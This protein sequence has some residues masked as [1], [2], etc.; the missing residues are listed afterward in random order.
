[1]ALFYLVCQK[2]AKKG[3][4]GADFWPSLMQVKNAWGHDN[5]SLLGMYRDA[6]EGGACPLV[7]DTTTPGCGTSRFGC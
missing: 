6:S 1:M 3:V 5:Q 4:I 7:V 2:G